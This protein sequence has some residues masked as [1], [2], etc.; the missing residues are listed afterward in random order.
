MAAKKAAPGRPKTPKWKGDDAQLR[1]EVRSACLAEF[2]C[3]FSVPW[4]PQ[5]EGIRGT[6]SLER[7]AR[8][9]F[10]ELHRVMGAVRE[11]NELA[12]A[13]GWH[14]PLAESERP[15]G[16]MGGRAT[17]WLL[18]R[19]LPLA[20]ES[21]MAQHSADALDDQAPLHD[22]ERVSLIR[23]WD[24]YDMGARIRTPREAAIVS[25]LSGI[26]PNLRLY[27]NYSAAD[28]IHEEE[29][30]IGPL[31]AGHQRRPTAH[32][33]RRAAWEWFTRFG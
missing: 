22:E 33:L 10:R 28:V 21:P 8:K 7:E 15:N 17:T 29:K 4:N 16:W 3:L 24:D 26:W 12:R 9:T 18:H 5:N 6:N 23:R 14:P 13:G 27:D 25:L 31:L 11:L 19:A 20:L 32:D 2:E 1:A 30:R